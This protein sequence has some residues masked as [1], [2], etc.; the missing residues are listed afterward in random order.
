MRRAALLILLALTAGCAAA[1]EWDRADTSAMQRQADERECL[2]EGERLAFD[3]SFRNRVYF[4]LP[5]PTVQAPSYFERGADT[6]RFAAECMRRR[7]YQLVPKA[8]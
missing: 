5:V 7:G 6:A 1:T 4:T 2:I 3:E 8:G